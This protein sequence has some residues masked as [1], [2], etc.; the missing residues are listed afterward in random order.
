MSGPRAS[1]P[2]RALLVACWLWGLMVLPPVWAGWSAPLPVPLHVWVDRDRSDS[3]ETVSHPDRQAD[4]Q[5][6]KGIFA[7]GFGRSVYW[8]RFELPVPQ[9]PRVGVPTWLLEVR[10]TYLDD[11]RFYFPDPARPGHYIEHRHGDRLPFNE[12]RVATRTFV[13]PAVVEQGDHWIGYAR[14][15]T[16]SSAV[17][18]LLVWDPTQF[19]VATTTEYALLGA[20]V[21]AFLFALLGQLPAAVRRNDP[22]S[23]WF[24][25]YVFSGLCIVVIV[26]GLAAQFIF[27]HSPAWA[28]LAT[29]MSSTLL[30]FTAT[31]FYRQA[32]HI[33]E[34]STWVNR[35]FLGVMGIALITFP[36]PLLDYY[37]VVAQLQFPALLLMLILG[38]VRSIQLIV[39]EDPDARWLLVGVL[40]TLLGAIPSVLALLGWVSG[41]LLMAY[42]YQAGILLSV[43]AIQIALNRR[44]R[45]AEQALLISRSEAARDR[46]MAQQQQAVA[47]QQ[48]RFIDMLTHE[49]KS[50]LSVMRMRLRSEKPSPRMQQHALQAV[51]DM[52]TL[53]ERIALA[54]R[55]EHGSLSM[56]LQPCRLDEA[57]REC[58]ASFPNANERVEVSSPELGAVPAVVMADPQ[59]LRVICLNLLDNAFKYADAEAGIRV[60]IG[61]GP[62]AEGRRGAWLRI[63]NPVG[64]AG[65]PDPQ[66]LFQK[67]YRGAAA[68]SLAG[69]GLGL[70]IVRSLCQEM[71]GQLK[72]CAGEPDVVF[73]LWLPQ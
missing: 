21:G 20:L 26:Q 4:F 63:C 41:D 62:F 15:E 42:A 64:A 10:P 9:S 27:P 60:L 3:I 2:V 46:A 59:W 16:S 37:P 65:K 33:A 8:F 49:L 35:L 55:L 45:R 11:V 6:V 70:Y 43:V 72:Y 34:W 36:A 12:R 18:S 57:L 69:T 44:A 14:L 29:P 50:P 23:H 58:L 25:A 31:G 67:Y 32:L 66:Q 17:F 53:V 5:A 51:Q 40:V 47:S 22:L 19:L 24:V 56:R 30:V 61:V 68:H 1:F 28:D 13:Q 71:G 73:E 52:D 7:G 39:H 48:R 38:V 54:G